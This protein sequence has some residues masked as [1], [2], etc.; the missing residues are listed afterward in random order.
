MKF[1]FWI[2]DFGFETFDAGPKFKVAEIR[3]THHLI[4]VAAAGI[5]SQIQ[6]P[7]S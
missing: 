7:K 5:R 4:N 6:N 2:S 3:L 1:G